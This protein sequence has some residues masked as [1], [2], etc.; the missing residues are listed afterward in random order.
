MTSTAKGRAPRTILVLAALAQNVSI[1]FTFGTY[2]VLL[3]GVEE[4]FGA[5]RSALG[6]GLALTTLVMGLLSP[7]VGSAMARLGAPHLTSARR[8]PP[9]SNAGCNA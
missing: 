9:P 2:G 3:L 4:T 8:E 6:A 5:S 7:A 1:G